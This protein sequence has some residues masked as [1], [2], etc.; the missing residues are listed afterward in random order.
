[1][2]NHEADCPYCDETLIEEWGAKSDDK[3]NEHDCLMGY[4]CPACD[5]SFTLQGEERG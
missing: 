5:K 2:Y 1:M 4:K 3:G